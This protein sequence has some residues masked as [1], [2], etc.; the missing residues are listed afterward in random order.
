MKPESK[1]FIFR[2]FVFWRILLFAFLFLAIGLVSLQH[3]YLGGGLSGQ[4]DYLGGGLSSYLKQPY[5]WAWGNFDGEHYLSIAYQGYQSLTY[6]FFPTYPLLI[7]FVAKFLG[8]SFKSLA[9]SGLLISNIS[10]YIALIGLWKLIKLDYKTEIARITLLLLLAFPTAFYFGSIYTESLF[11]ALVVWSFYFARKRKWVAAGIL[12]ALLTATR[13]VGLAI[14]PALLVEA[15]LQRRK[16]KKLNLVPVV[17]GLLF[18][19]LGIV[20]YMFYLNVVTGDPLE[21][22]HNVSIFGQQRSS[23]LVLLPQVFY[24]YFFKVLPNINYSYFPI[25]F[26]TYLEIVTALVFLG[27]AIVSFFKIRLSYAFYLA[28][29]YIIPTLSGSFSSFHRYVLILFPAFI[30][31]AIWLSKRKKWVGAII[32]TILILGLLVATSLFARG[33]WVA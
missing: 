8:G 24:R 32:F 31:T 12:G 9:V 5:L 6:F 22:F 17:I 26:V 7:A 3:K 10:F 23:N 20:A 29:G 11:L 13:V 33:Y 27:L 16:D 18:S 15:Y 2:S 28:I 19:V 1:K 4:Q 30:L 14:V 25:V 21:F